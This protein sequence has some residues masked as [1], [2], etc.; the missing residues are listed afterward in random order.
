MKRRPRI[1]SREQLRQ[2][3]DFRTPE[4]RGVAVVRRDPEFALFQIAWMEAQK[5]KPTMFEQLRKAL[6]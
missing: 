1:T 5:A 3:L 6:E 2:L 4:E